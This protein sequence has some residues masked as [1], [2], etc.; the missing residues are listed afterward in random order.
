[1]E[2]MLIDENLWEVS[3]EEKAAASEVTKVAAWNKKDDKARA[4]I[5]LLVEDNQLLHI[6]KAKTA[7]ASLTV[8][9]EYHQK[10]TLTSKVLL[11]KR[12]CRTVLIESGDMEMHISTFSNNINQLSA[13]GQ[14]L[15]DNLI[16]ALL[17]ES[18]PESYDN[19]VTALETRPESDTTINFIKSKLIDE[20]KRRKEARDVRDNFQENEAA[21]KIMHSK[22]KAQK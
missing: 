6:R 21:M 10:C 22:D 3:S 7:M 12:I 18:L 8:L 2:L 4:R 15:P 11:L 14:D 13:L 16:A 9:K 19:L 1:M 17:L 20:F 5:G